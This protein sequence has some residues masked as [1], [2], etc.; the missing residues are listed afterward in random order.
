MQISSSIGSKGPAGGI[1]FGIPQGT[2]DIDF[3]I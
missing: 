3:P 1:L 2:R